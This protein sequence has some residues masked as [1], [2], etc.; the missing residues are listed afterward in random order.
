MLPGGEGARLR[1]PTRSQVGGLLP[2]RLGPALDATTMLEQTWRR[3][4]LSIADER[5]LTMG[6]P[7]HREL[8]QALKAVAPGEVVLQPDDRGSA[9]ALLYALLR[10]ARDMPR[11]VVAVFPPDHYVNDNFRFM[12]YVKTAFNSISMYSGLIVVLG[13]TADSPQMSYGWI[14][15]GEVIPSIWNSTGRIQRI[16][17]FWATSSL[18]VAEDLYSRGCLWNSSVMVADIQTLLSLFAAALP[19]LYTGFVAIRPTLGTAFER[20]AVELLYNTL[21]PINFADALMANCFGHWAVIPVN[22]LE[23]VD[24]G[25]PER[26]P[27]VPQQ[28]MVP[29][30]VR[31]LLHNDL[32]TEV[33][34]MTSLRGPLHQRLPVSPPET[35]L[36][37]PTLA[38]SR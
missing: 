10:L 15:P 4:G 24:M 13:I 18:R 3:V 1:K 16:R 33:S 25:T 34:R 20:K 11:G 6:T 17:R 36:K 27:A 22:G 30:E 7:A 19:A 2:K 26:L 32:S 29:S 37:Q 8:F 38:L 5:T 14:E 21:P 31:P 23:W 35:G 12:E 28:Y 9:P